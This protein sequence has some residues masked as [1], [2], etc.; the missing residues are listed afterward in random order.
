[1]RHESSDG[2][3]I[4]AESAERIHATLELMQVYQERAEAK[5]L[6]IR[7]E[8][9]GRMTSR[10][11]RS[12]FWFASRGFQEL[13]DLTDALESMNKVLLAISTPLPVLGSYSS[14]N[15]G[16]SGVVN[17]EEGI[18]LDSPSDVVEAEATDVPISRLY[19]ECLESL[20][21]LSRYTI[22][23][24]SDDPS[25]EIIYD[26][27][28]RWGAGIFD[29][30]EDANCDKILDEDAWRRSTLRGAIIQVLVYIAVIEGEF[31][32]VLRKFF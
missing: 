19:K 2:W 16:A 27:L 25:T 23:E 30:R 4:P 7:E 10:V 11:L 12:R 9:D 20:G 17:T 29:D 3:D 18:N 24:K 32:S 21:I 8:P 15:Q 28:K 14:S 22:L 1:V 5:L 31:W 26:H 6:R 13:K